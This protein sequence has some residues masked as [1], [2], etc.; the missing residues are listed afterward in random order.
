MRGQVVA[1]AA[2]G[3]GRDRR[4]DIG[5]DKPAGGDE[6]ATRLCCL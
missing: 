5:M 3:G 2:P 1:A 6:S 4:L